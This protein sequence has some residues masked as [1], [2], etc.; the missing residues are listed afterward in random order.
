MSDWP[1]LLYVVI[2]TLLYART[3]R[4]RRDG[5]MSRATWGFP[6]REDYTPEGQRRLRVMWRFYIIGALALLLWAVVNV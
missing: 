6:R 2:G 1:L 5:S 3:W 4:H